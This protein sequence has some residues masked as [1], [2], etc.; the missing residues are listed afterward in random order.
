MI[1]TL[2]LRKTMKKSKPQRPLANRKIIEIAKEELPKYGEE[3]CPSWVE[4]HCRETGRPCG[5]SSCPLVQHFV[6][7]V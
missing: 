2:E 6:E 1:F 4:G 3:K 5:F 7:E